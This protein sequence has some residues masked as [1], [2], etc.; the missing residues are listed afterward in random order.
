MHDHRAER[1]FSDL[2]YKTALKDQ[3]KAVYTGLI[4]ITK[5]GQ[6]S[7]A[8]QA[9]RNLL[10]SQGAQADSVPMLEIEADDVRCTHGVAVGPV[11][12]D[13][14]FYL[15]SRGIPPAEAQRLIVAGFFEQVMRR[16]PLPSLREELEAEVVRRLEAPHG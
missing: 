3:A 13:Q 2:L 12:P 7:D 9:N 15:T 1:T 14:E 8:Y 16:V 10:L 11:D 6:K 5:E 4:R